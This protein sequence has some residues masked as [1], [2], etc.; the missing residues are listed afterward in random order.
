MSYRGM[1]APLRILRKPQARRKSISQ[2]LSGE[3][4]HPL[5]PGRKIALGQPTAM[6]RIPRAKAKRR[7]LSVIVFDRSPLPAHRMGHSGTRIIAM[8][9]VSI[10]AL[11]PRY[12]R[13]F[14][15][16]GVKLGFDDFDRLLG[17]STVELEDVLRSAEEQ[18]NED[19]WRGRDCVH[20]G[21]LAY[22][23]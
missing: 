19:R 15:S 21:R 11:R 14:S 4:R 6:L 16:S 23:H 2:R 17:V 7:A 8:S 13:C 9:T 22:D 10:S 1:G 20:S 3:H 12:S 5:T 18:E